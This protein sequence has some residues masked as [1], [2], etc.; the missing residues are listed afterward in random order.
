MTNRYSLN[1]AHLLGA[2]AQL[3]KVAVSFVMVVR[4]PVCTNVSATGTALLQLIGFL[5]SLVFE[6]VQVTVSQQFVF[7][8]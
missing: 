6:Y 3:R 7:R 8:L 2:F 5:C 1:V 4:P